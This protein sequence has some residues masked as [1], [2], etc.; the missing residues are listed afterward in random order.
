MWEIIRGG[1]A[2]KFANAQDTAIKEGEGAA[3]EFEL[4]K[5][6]IKGGEAWNPNAHKAAENVDNKFS[7]ITYNNIYI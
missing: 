4:S 6:N 3:S 7:P 2:P 5:H 1:A